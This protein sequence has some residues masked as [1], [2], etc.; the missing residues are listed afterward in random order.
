MAG[1]VTVGIFHKAAERAELRRPGLL[2]RKDAARAGSPPR[3][4][5]FM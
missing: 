5:A 2:P 1:A 3:C 4:V